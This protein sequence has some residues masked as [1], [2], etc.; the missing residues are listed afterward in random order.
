MLYAHIIAQIETAVK[1]V[2][3]AAQ[4]SLAWL[5]I[6]LMVALAG[7]E[8]L[9]I[10]RLFRREDERAKRDDEAT[11]ARVQALSNNTEVLRSVQVTMMQF[12][13]TLRDLRSFL[14]NQSKGN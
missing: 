9:I 13:E 2:D 11:E 7:F 4:Q 3:H 14:D 6:A 12:N 1:L 5:V 10:S 8:W